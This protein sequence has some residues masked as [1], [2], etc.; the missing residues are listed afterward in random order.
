MKNEEGHESLSIPMTEGHIFKVNFS[1]KHIDEKL[2]AEAC[3]LT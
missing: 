1:K 2:I 3:F